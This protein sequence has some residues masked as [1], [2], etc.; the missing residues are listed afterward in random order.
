MS[1]T[2]PAESSE[3]KPLKKI[4]EIMQVKKLSEFAIIPTR[5]SKYA[6]GNDDQSETSRL[7]VYF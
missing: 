3:S 4:S 5:G 1:I 2:I 7:P 6:A